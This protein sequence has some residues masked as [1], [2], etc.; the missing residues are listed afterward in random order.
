MATIWGGS[1]IR[2]CPAQYRYSRVIEGTRPPG[3]ARPVAG[4]MK[5]LIK[6]GDLVQE[7]T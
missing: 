6:L 5:S 2:P 7:G 3:G 4:V 1:S